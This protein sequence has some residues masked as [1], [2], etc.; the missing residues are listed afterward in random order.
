VPAAR[1]GNGAQA[2]QRTAQ[3]LAEVHASLPS[4]TR[5][6]YAKTLIVD[7]GARAASFPGDASYQRT[8]KGIVVSYGGRAY[9]YP[10]S[11]S[12]RLQSGVERYVYPN[13]PVPNELKSQR[14]DT[15]GGSI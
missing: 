2:Q 5:I 9:T 6:Y 8:A 10:A 12:V 15:M 3:T 1:P 11:A 13:D 4:G 7:M 14:Y